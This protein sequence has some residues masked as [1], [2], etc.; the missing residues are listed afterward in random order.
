MNALLRLGLAAAV[1]LAAPVA[2][3]SENAPAHHRHHHRDRPVAQAPAP[4]PAQPA[5]TAEGGLL[6]SMFKPFARPGEADDDGLS[7]DSDDCMKGCI[8]GESR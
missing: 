8:G 2:W 3:A 5:Q 1:L 7:R 6:G 4:A